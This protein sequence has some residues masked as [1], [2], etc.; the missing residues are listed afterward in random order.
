MR[1]SKIFVTVDALIFKKNQFKTLL[2]LIQRKNPPF[3]NSWA[4]PGG[5]V[6]ENEDI[7][8][9]VLRELYEETQI[10]LNS[11]EQLKTFGKPFR[12]PRSHVVSIAYYGFVLEEVEAKAADDAKAVAWFSTTEL[13]ELAFDHIEIINFAL[14]KIE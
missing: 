11:L 4:L 14:N 7:D 2:L 3:Q 8:R 10:K 5:F 9:A 13:P 6:N 12:D 1:N